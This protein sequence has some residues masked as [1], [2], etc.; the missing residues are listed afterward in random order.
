MQL[1]RL[2]LTLRGA[3]LR[4][5]PLMRDSRVPV[6][7]K[8]GA[9]LAGVFIVSPLD[10]LSDIPVLGLIDDAVLLLLLSKLFV[11]LAQRWTRDEAVEPRLVTPAQLPTE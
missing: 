7:L 10:P 11:A 9:I 3:V 1:F 6:W 4:V 2:F 5:L 8:A